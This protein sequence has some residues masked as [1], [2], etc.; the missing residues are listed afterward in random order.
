MRLE[1]F[2]MLDRI[3][4]VDVDERRHPHGLHHPESE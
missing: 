2:Q 4:D 3:V 1:Y